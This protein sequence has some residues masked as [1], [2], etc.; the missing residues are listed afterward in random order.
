MK[1]LHIALL[2]TNYIPIT[3]E[4]K[5]G[6]ELFIHL[7]CQEL[8][9]Y[10]ST[11]ALPHKVTIHCA[12]D[13]DVPFPIISPLNQSTSRIP[14]IPQDLYKWHELDHISMAFSLQE[15]YDLFHIHLSNGEWIL[16][17]LPFIKKPIL[18]T[19]HGGDEAA[20]N[21]SLFHALSQYSN[22]HFVSISHAQRRKLPSLPYIQTI[23]HGVDIH[24]Q[25]YFS[26][27]GGQNLF[28]AGRA[29][30]QKGLH[31][32]IEVFKETKYPLVISPIEIPTSHDYIENTLNQ[33]ED[34]LKTLGTFIVN[35]NL[36][37]KEVSEHFRN[38]KAF[39]FP[40]HWEEP[41]G[42][43]LAESLSSGTPIIAFAKGSTTEIVQDGITGFL[44]NESNEDIR[45][46]YIT[47]QTGT[48]GIIEAVHHIMNLSPADYKRMR[49]ACR[50]DA[51]ERFSRKR[52]I[53]D[54][55]NLMHKICS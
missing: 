15:S 36:E 25:Y 33:H 37:R 13:S 10:I 24:N 53:H 3:S 16:P 20:Y 47:K 34:Q 27:N 11:N 44:V 30:P 48:Q 40:I 12:K 42:L 21:S 55:M 8:F 38:S 41:F 49:Y 14:T 5:K 35:R 17:F 32:A 18:V 52:M 7:Y 50:H 28:W 39:L 9:D 26:E 51:E 31:T 46:K 54:Y 45:G 2:A 29:I 43:V 19:M 1:P 6:T 23:Y 22:I 4:I